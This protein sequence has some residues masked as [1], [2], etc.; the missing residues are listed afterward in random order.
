MATLCLSGA[1]LLKAGAGV[2]S[3]FT[4]G[5]GEANLVPLINQAEAYV[6]VLT[7]YDWIGNWTSLDAQDK[8]L[9]E[10]AASDLAAIYAIQ[11]DM[12]G[13]TNRLEAQTMLDVLRDRFVQAVDLLKVKAHSDDYLG[14]S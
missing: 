4:G 10:Q 8:L 9:L 2:S 1:V 11:Y 6:N 3:N 14:A 12:S 5:N 13:Y 7:R